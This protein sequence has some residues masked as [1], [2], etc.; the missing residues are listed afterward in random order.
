[1]SR[2]T[3]FRVFVCTFVLAGLALPV[4]LLAQHDSQFYGHTE[5]IAPDR[6]DAGDWYGTWFYTSRTRKIALWI[7]ETDGLP[8]IKMRL[9]DRGTGSQSFTTNWNT[10]ADYNLSG[11]HGL[12]SLDIE[13]RDENTLT[14]K[15]SWAMRTGDARNGEEAVFTIYRSGVGRQLVIDF[16]DFE[17]TQEHRKSQRLGRMVWT[18]HKAS[19]RE[20]LWSELPF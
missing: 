13:T 12:F 8:Q 7:R 6:T 9:Q 14:G 1:M 15:W 3:V 10:Q 5:V 18:F 11:L 19:R 16:E 4:P 2:V 20:A 17:R